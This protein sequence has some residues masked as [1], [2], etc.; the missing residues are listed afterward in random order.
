MLLP[1]IGSWW[2]ESN[3]GG[4][5][6]CK[7][8]GSGRSIVGEKVSPLYPQGHGVN[9]RTRTRVMTNSRRGESHISPRRL[10]NSR[11]VR[12]NPQ[13]DKQDKQ[14]NSPGDLEHHRAECGV[15]LT[16]RPNQLLRNRLGCYSPLPTPDRHARKQ[17]PQNSVPR[18]RGP[19]CINACLRHQDLI[20]WSQMWYRPIVLSKHC[21]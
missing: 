2:I 1:V 6:C 5:V 16:S 11:R 9:V 8:L 7:T 4:V 18:F 15:G 3:T 17:N 20:P 14:T 12:G 13:A 19:R 21:T 10:P